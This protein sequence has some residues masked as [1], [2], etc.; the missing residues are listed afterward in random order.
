MELPA[1][2]KIYL[3]VSHL[4]PPYI[5]FWKEK[6]R[7]FFFFINIKIKKKNI[8]K[9]ELGI[10]IFLWTNLILCLLLLNF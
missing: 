5:E 7:I 1:E 10:C 6:T 8:I 2:E 4:S 9:M 3:I